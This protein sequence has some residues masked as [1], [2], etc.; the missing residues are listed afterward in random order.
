M[1]CQIR[2]WQQTWKL[3]MRSWP[4][5]IILTRGRD[6][7]RESISWCPLPTGHQVVTLSL[8]LLSSHNIVLQCDIKYLQD[9]SADWSRRVCDLYLGIDSRLS[10]MP[11]HNSLVRARAKAGAMRT[12]GRNVRHSD[13]RLSYEHSL[14]SHAQNLTFVLGHYFPNSSRRNIYFLCNAD[15]L[16]KI[17]PFNYLSL[18]VLCFLCESESINK[19]CWTFGQHINHLNVFVCLNLNK[20]LV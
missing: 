15:C 3:K 6:L 9:E 12:L 2:Y 14:L 11:G 17:D 13:R 16:F 8:L 4:N 5:T 7:H 1:W 18:L 20:S 10:P 19:L